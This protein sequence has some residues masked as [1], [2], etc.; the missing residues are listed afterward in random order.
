MGE[1]DMVIS[2]TVVNYTYNSFAFIP[3]TVLGKHVYMYMCRFVILTEPGYI[4]SRTC[5]VCLTRG[6]PCW[7]T[8]LQSGLCNFK[9]MMLQ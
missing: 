6:Q 1:K 8:A 9:Y 4:I 2:A 5:I 3:H 7:G